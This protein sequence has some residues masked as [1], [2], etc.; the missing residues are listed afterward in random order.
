MEML[1]LIQV[2]RNKLQTNPHD[3]SCLLFALQ[4]PSV[5]SRIDFP[6]TPENTGECKDGKFYRANGKI[7]DANMYKAWLRKHYSHFVNI[8]ISPG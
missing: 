2:Y 3:T 5:C 1:D 6:Q 7:W 8:S 4:I